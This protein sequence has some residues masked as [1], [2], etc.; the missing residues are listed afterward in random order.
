MPVLQIVSSRPGAG[1]STVAV[2]MASGLAGGGEVWLVRTGS[3]PAATEDAITFASFGFASSPGSVM[4]VSG[5]SA[6][7][8]SALVVL[9]DDGGAAPQPGASVI[10]AV[11][12]APG[13]EDL[14]LGPQIGDRLLGTVAANVAS[15]A[16]EPVARDLTNA[17]LRPLALLPEDRALAAPSVA[18][19]RDCLGAEL[20]YDGENERDVVEDVLIGPVYADPARPH[21]GRFASKAILTPFNKTD[22]L[23]AA[24]ESQAACLVITGGRQPSPYVLD[25]VHGEATTILLAPRE[26]PET[27]AS[28]SDVWQTSRFR[29]ESK[30][31]AAVSHLAGRV[32]FASLLRRIQ[33]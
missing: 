28:L 25:R 10:L 30:A 12:G 19:L 1:K 31:A 5:L 32:D 2:A 21:F 13:E 3:G 24:I 14:A 23:L 33:G 18:E 11:N 4:P 22:L 26:T 20:L 16:V 8:P 6:L 17:G 7:A 27:L 9:E 15:S 29:G